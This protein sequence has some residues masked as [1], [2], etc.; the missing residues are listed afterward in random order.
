MSTLYIKHV[1]PITEGTKVILKRFTVF[2]GPQSSGKS[3]IAKLISALMWIEK[4]ACTTLSENVLPEGESFKDFVENF[5][6]MHGY[7]DEELSLI[8]YESEFIS[9]RYEHG[10]HKLTLKDNNQYHRVKVS[11]MP[12]DRNVAT[13]KDLEKRDLEPTNFRSFLFD[14][15]ECN[16]N[17]D[18]EHKADIL[19]LGVKYYYDKNA[20]EK[21]DKIIH[22]NGVTYDIPLY[23]ASSGLQSVVPL[24]V[25]MDYLTSQYLVDYGKTTSFDTVKKKEQLIENLIK[26]YI[27]GTEDNA[28][29]L[30]KKLNDQAQ[31]GDAKAIQVIKQLYQH[32]QNLTN[33]DRISFI[34]E[35]PEQNLFTQT[36]VEVLNEIIAN[37]NRNAFHTAVVTTHSP[38]V[39]ATI[40]N[41]LLAGKLKNRDIDFSELSSIVRPDSILDDSEIMVYAVG[42]GTCHSIIN[43]DTGLINQNELDVASDYNAAV[44]EKLYRIYIKSLRR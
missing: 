16:K 20:K 39:L 6:R 35:E 9:F 43:K 18:F 22:S 33:P 8:K 17:Y 5:H 15:L 10:Q 37:C 41:L 7:I 31:T 29:S 32:F 44:F 40:N 36:Q 21:K 42:N 14:W 1:G 30:F 13:M 24:V 27:H 2:I 3:T 28:G 38:Y 23:D 4:E 12:A 11:Y 26:K 34:L 19:G 25:L